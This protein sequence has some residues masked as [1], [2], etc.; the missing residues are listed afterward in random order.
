MDELEIDQSRLVSVYFSA[1]SLM[2]LALWLWGINAY[3]WH[4][5]MK[6]VPSPLVVFSEKHTKSFANEDAIPHAS[7]FAN[8]FVCFSL[9]T[10]NGDGTNFIFS[11]HKYTFIPHNHSANVIKLGALKYTDTNLDWSISNSS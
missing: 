2:T 3:L 11:C 7:S 10:T 6:L 1:P 5:K 4:E 8:D 9:N